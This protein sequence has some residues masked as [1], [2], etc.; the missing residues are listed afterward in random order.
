MTKA[1][2]KYFS[3]VDS[4]ASADYKTFDKTEITSATEVFQVTCFVKPAYSDISS[5]VYTDANI[6][7]APYLGHGC[8]EIKYIQPFTYVEGDDEWTQLTSA[9][10][11]ATTAA[12][13]VEYHKS[14]GVSSKCGAGT[15]TTIHDVFA[16]STLK[17]K[18]DEITNFKLQISLSDVGLGGT[19]FADPIES[20]ITVETFD[21]VGNVEVF[22]LL[23][24]S[25]DYETQ[26]WVGTS[27][28]DT[29]VF[30]DVIAPNGP[31]NTGNVV[32]AGSLSHTCTADL[33]IV[34]PNSDFHCF[35][36]TGIAIRDSNAFYDS[37]YLNQGAS[38]SDCTAELTS[39]CETAQ[40]AAPTITDSRNC[41]DDE[42]AVSGCS[43]ALPLTQISALKTSIT[44]TSVIIDAIR[45]HDDHTFPKEH[46]SGSFDATDFDA[47]TTE[48][49]CDSAECS[50]DPYLVLEKDV[51]TYEY[52]CKWKSPSFNGGVATADG[53]ITTGGQVEDV[54]GVWQDNEFTSECAASGATSGSIASTAILLPGKI[55]PQ[56]YV[57]GITTFIKESA[58]DLVIPDTSGVQ[59]RRLGGSRTIAPM[60]ETKTVFVMAP[61]KVISK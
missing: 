15:Q 31:H 16:W 57:Y 29:V 9:A 59:L 7:A 33:E 54:S 20:D 6:Q 39:S 14:V 21:F 18:Y 19:P 44:V 13:E 40:I 10:V 52:L 56:F 26:E 60:L 43:E 2:Y 22:D 17:T 25:G 41:L 24:I 30:D 47:K 28:I 3:I 37:T 48:F 32:V 23:Y 35:D 58:S 12:D 53:T 1:S 51:G 45:L 61:Q 38:V 49:N 36:A 34:S 55:F 8:T 4:S 42:T 11:V 46:V 50:S 5:N 27:D